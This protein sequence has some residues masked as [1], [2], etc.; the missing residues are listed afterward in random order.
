MYFHPFGGGG[1]PTEPP[2]YLGFR[3][4]GK[5]QSIHHV[6]GYE[7]VREMHSHIPEFEK[8][9]WGKDFIL[10][11][12]GNPIL[13]DHDVRTGK[14]FRNGRVWA[15]IDTLLTSRTISEARDITKKRLDKS[16]PH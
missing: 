5:L 7:I 6:E 4:F 12:L 16:S 11:R 3:Y 15:M 14:I 10:Y 1:W 8:G 13:P 9:D 2:N